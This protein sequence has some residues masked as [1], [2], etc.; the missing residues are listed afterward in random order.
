MPK[1]SRLSVLK[2][3]MLGEIDSARTQL[4]QGA[5]PNEK[6]TDGRTPLHWA[7]QEGHIKIIRL[8]IES[9]AKADTADNLGFTP[10]VIAAGEGNCAGVKELIKA[11]ADA[12]IRVHSN[13]DG[14]ALHLACAWDHLDVAKILIETSDADINGKDREGRTP[15]A[16]V[17]MS[18][19]K[20]ETGDKKLADY[21]IDHG[22]IC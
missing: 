7:C 3:A 1:K 16:L 9:G 17:M 2:E 21:L 15:L 14:T 10:L 12:N 11:G 18:G 5:D 4:K 22:A 8:L 19:T 6:D 20:G 13:S